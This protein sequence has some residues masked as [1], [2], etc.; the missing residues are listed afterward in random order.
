MSRQD[1]LA[2]LGE[3]LQSWKR[4]GLSSAC[5]NSNRHANRFAGSMGARSSISPRTIILVWRTI[6]KLVEASVEAAKRFG[7]GSGAV[8]TIS[9]TMSLHVELE[10]RIAAFKNV[11]ACVVFQSGFAANSG[12]VSA[13][14]G[15]GRSHH[16]RRTESREH[17]RWLPPVEGKDPRLCSSRRKCGRGETPRTGR[18]CPGRKLLITDGVFSMDGDI[19]PLRGAG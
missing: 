1:P 11:E 16:F 19:G 5:G 15:P 18:R 14:L 8:R 6:P 3:Q 4:Q 13:V 10:E 17:H 12:T 7:A 9:G 2:Y